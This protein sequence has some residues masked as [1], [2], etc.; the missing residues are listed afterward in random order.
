MATET[1]TVESKVTQENIDLDSLF[2]GPTQEADFSFAD[3][4]GEVE[5]EAAKETEVETEANAEETTETKSEAKESAKEVFE[6]IQEELA[7][8]RGV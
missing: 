5:E 6:R 2:D 4:E 7:G 3:P 8:L 1:K